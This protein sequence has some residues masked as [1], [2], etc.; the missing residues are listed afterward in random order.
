MLSILLLYRICS[1]ICNQWHTTTLNTENPKLFF[2]Q[3]Q[4]ID[5]WD[6][7]ND[8]NVV[9]SNTNNNDCMLSS[10]ITR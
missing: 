2:F 7:Q 8:Y 9:V 4:I 3:I 10:N 6:V 1:I 5:F